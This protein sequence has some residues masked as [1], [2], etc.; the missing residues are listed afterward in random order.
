[1]ENFM[2]SPWN[3]SM[4]KIFPKRYLR[5]LPLSSLSFFFQAEVGMRYVAVTGV[6]RCAL[7]ISVPAGQ[8]ATF[9]VAASG[10]APLSYQ[11]KKNGTAVSG[12][13]SASYTTPASSSSDNGAL[14]NVVVS[15]AS[16]SVTS[17]IATLTDRK[18]VV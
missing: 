11:W 3:S 10:T 6:Q 18:S 14:F 8:T 5:D 7:P 2:S 9:S 16:G 4:V 17:N 1:M 13:T 15:N 12:A